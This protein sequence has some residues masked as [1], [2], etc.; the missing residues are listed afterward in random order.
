MRTW[1]ALAVCL[2][3][4]PALLG[5]QARRVDTGVKVKDVAPLKV[6]RV[7]NWWQQN[8]PSILKSIQS[9]IQVDERVLGTYKSGRIDPRLETDVDESPWKTASRPAVFKTAKIKREKVKEMEASIARQK[10]RLSRL[11]NDAEIHYPIAWRADNNDLSPWDVNEAGNIGR[12]EAM[13]VV[14][15]AGPN[16]VVVKPFEWVEVWNS[17]PSNHIAPTYYTRRRTDRITVL[18][19]GV[20]SASYS[21]LLG[22]VVFTNQ[23]FELREAS[24]ESK[25]SGYHYE[26]DPF[27]IEP[28]LDRPAK[29]TQGKK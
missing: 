18:L 3:L 26:A 20:D 8:K 13:L 2:F 1:V 10:T 4:V 7:W 24:K 11:E 17:S 14:S 15:I 25:T 27:D 16:A 23:A 19:R 5:Q 21:E 28:W 12:F 29:E 9:D 6:A 22:Q